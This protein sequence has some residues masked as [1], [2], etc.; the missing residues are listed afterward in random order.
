MTI[1][2]QSAIPEPGQIVAVRQRRY[3]VAEVLVSALPPAPLAEC[4]E[5]S[6]H[7]LMLNSIEDDDLGETWQ[8]IW[9]IEPGTSIEEKFDLPQPE[10][11]DSPEWLD[12][13]LN[14][15]R[16]GA[17]SSADMR[18]L[19]APFRSGNEIEDYQLDPLVGVMP[20]TT[21]SQPD[22]TWPIRRS[23]LG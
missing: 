5:P 1:T 10:G 11:F 22:R 12:A 6:H 13:F 18:A 9:E 23:A 2:I 14:A 19:E 20:V 17:V 8:M 15:V 21:H 3:V 16:W 4:M 7:L